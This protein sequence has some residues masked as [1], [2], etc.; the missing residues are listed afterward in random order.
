M[1]TP[2]QESLTSFSTAHQQHPPP[3]TPD[4]SSASL[5]V[6]SLYGWGWSGGEPVGSILATSFP[7]CCWLGTPGT[8]LP[9][10]CSRRHNSGA[11]E[12]AHS[13][14]RDTVRHP[15]P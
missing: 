1:K 5:V 4:F 15:E 10:A 9:P 12:E 2:H 14:R 11:Q 3:H 8:P 6:S 13:L 7:Y